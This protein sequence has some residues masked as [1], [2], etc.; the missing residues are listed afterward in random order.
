MAMIILDRLNQK[1]NV[2]QVRT[3]MLE[4]PLVKTKIRREIL[5]IKLVPVG[6]GYLTKKYITGNATWKSDKI[7]FSVGLIGNLCELKDGRQALT[8]QKIN[9]VYLNE[10][11]YRRLDEI[12]EKILRNLLPC[13]LKINP[14][15]MEF[16]EPVVGATGR[17]IA[18][19]NPGSWGK[20]SCGNFE[21]SE[22]AKARMQHGA[23]LHKWCSRCA[24]LKDA[25]GE[26]LCP[27]AAQIAANRRAPLAQDEPQLKL[28]M[29]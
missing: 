9:G 11:W 16:T 25:E 10:A 13:I 5:T 19:I 18:L 4:N 27:V 20:Q 29:V 24:H 7:N 3:A 15:E 22:E 28:A 21:W 6:T 12:L 17:E 26:T 2:E 14:E 8:L 23:T 1:L